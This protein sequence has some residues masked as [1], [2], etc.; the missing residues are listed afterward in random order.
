MKLSLKQWGAFLS[1]LT[2]VVVAVL[3]LAVTGSPW[4]WRALPKPV[5]SFCDIAGATDHYAC[6]DIKAGQAV[7]ISVC[8]WTTFAHPEASD[9]LPVESPQAP[10]GLRTIKPPHQTN[11]AP[12]KSGNQALQLMKYEITQYSHGCAMYPPGKEPVAA[13]TASGLWPVVG[14]TAA[15]D[16]S[17]AF[18]REVLIEGLG[19]WTVHD[20]GSAIVGRRLDLFVNTC[21]EARKFG[22]QWRT[23]I[24]VPFE[25]TREANTQLPMSGSSR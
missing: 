19:Y 8:N 21:K 15:A 5:V 17:L 20:R 7:S 23:V 14:Q 10:L 16:R 13:R 11:P 25:T 18:G 1:A 3:T 2:L 6:G 4:M 22:R 12:V 9:C 24:V